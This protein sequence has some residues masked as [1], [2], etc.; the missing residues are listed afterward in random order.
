MDRSPDLCFSIVN[1]PPSKL[2]RDRHCRYRQC[3][4]IA[5]EEQAGYIGIVTGI[6]FEEDLMSLLKRCLPSAGLLLVAVMMLPYPG[7]AQV[8]VD[9]HIGPPLRLTGSP[10]RRR[11]S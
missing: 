9:V 8:R 7:T 3:G 4:S 11:W 2:D 10:L 6:L 1:N 5:P